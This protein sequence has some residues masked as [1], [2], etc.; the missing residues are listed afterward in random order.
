ERIAWERSR[1]GERAIIDICASV[2]AVGK[3]PSSAVLEYTID[4]VRDEI[5]LL[6]TSLA[7]FQDLREES[8]EQL[9]DAI[10]FREIAR[11][12]CYVRKTFDNKEAYAMALDAYEDAN[13]SLN[14]SVEAAFNIRELLARDQQALQLLEASFEIPRHHHARK[15]PFYQQELRGGLEPLNGD[16][17]RKEYRNNFL[18]LQDLSNLLTSEDSTAG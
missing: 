8:K 10:E 17:P 3:L 11:R 13:E 6:E 9:L 7:D 1:N 15:L 18:G 4:C 16:G 5:A 14:R 2:V 12:A